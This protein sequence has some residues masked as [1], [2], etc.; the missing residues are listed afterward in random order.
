MSELK[1]DDRECARKSGA[2]STSKTKGAAGL[3]LFLQRRVGGAELLALLRH[4]D[5]AE[6]AVTEIALTAIR[7]DSHTRVK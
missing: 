4:L 3:L 2:T 6:I 7:Q 1:L 5:R